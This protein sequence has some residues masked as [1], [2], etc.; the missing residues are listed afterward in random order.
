MSEFIDEDIDEDQ[1]RKDKLF[2]IIS[3][4]LLIIVVVI[5]VFVIVN[6]KKTEDYK[7]QC[8]DNP[9]LRFAYPCSTEKECI[10]MCVEGLRETRGS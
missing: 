9:R 1:R 4:I 5:A 7:G 8:E 2:L 10:D 6:H 3:A